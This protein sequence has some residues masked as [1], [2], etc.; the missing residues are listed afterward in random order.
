MDGM[1]ASTYAHLMAQPF[2]LRERWFDVSLPEFEAFL[3]SYPRPLE[4]RPPLSSKANYREW[5]DPILGTWPG[6]AVG[7]TWRRGGCLGCQIRL[8]LVLKAS[9]QERRGCQSCGD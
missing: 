9:A 8:D 1:T 6:N 2:E 7:K 3:R 5:V 4:P